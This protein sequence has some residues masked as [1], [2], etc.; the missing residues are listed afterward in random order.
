MIIPKQRYLITVLGSLLYSA[1]SFAQV[2]ESTPTSEP[3]PV[4]AAPAVQAKSAETTQSAKDQQI[5]PKEKVAD[6]FA[7]A[8]FSW[9]PG[10]AGPNE[11]PLSSKMFTGELR[12]DTAYHYSFRNPKD[13]TISGS[14]EVFRHGEFQVTQ[15]GVGGDFFYKNVMAR[16]MTQ[17]GMYLRERPVRSLNV[18]GVALPSF[19][20]IAL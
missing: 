4:A 6:P 7:F 1:V 3:T 2:N 20:S 8:D 10:N 5:E 11:H 13:D 14:S 18:A 17:F 9:V 12:V 19:T 15:L 16:L